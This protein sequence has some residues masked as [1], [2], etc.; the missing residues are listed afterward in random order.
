LGDASKSEN[1]GLRGARW[2]QC[3]RTRQCCRYRI[4]LAIWHEREKTGVIVH[5][6][7]MLIRFGFAARV[8]PDLRLVQSIVPPRLRLPLIG[9]L[10]KWIFRPRSKLRVT[11]TAQTLVTNKKNKEMAA[12]TVNDLYTSLNSPSACSQIRKSLYTK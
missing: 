11:M 4:Q 5:P 1:A 3:K 10:D 8:M 12:N 6:Y 7:S 2:A 9:C